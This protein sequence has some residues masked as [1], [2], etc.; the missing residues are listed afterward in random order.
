MKKKVLGLI[1]LQI[2]PNNATP[3]PPIGPA[4]GQRG[5]NIMDFCRQFNEKTK[6]MDK[7]LKIPVEITFYVNKTFDFLIK[8]PPASALIKKY[9]GIKTGGKMPGKEEHVGKITKSEIRK[10]AEIKLP[11]TNTYNIDSA[12][13]IV[14]GTALSIGIKII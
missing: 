5:L 13:K 6:N 3:A 2:N 10:I 1:K 12:I 11:E 8:S 14:E 7:E 4:L 9:S